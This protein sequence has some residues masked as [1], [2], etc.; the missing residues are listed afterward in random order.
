MTDKSAVASNEA[1][2]VGESGNAAP[3]IVDLGS[4]KRGQIK[5]LTK[6][7]GPLRDRVLEVID[8][9]RADGTVGASA[10]PVIVVVKKKTSSKNLLARLF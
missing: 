7:Q 3:V 4:A 6:G 9:L 5:Q 1:S 10:Q 2:K 8:S